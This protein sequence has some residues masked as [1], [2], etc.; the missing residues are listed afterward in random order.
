MMVKGVESVHF[1]EFLM[2]KAAKLR[3]D[4]GHSGC[5]H[6]G[7]AADLERQVETYRAAQNKEWPSHWAK[8]LSQFQREQDADYKTYL[9]LKKRFEG[10]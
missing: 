3:D 2:K 8:D 10:R 7:G 9:E 5:H 4:A 6:D 1:L